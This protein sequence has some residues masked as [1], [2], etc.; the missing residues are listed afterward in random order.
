MIN[1]V[2]IYNMTHGCRDCCDI[3]EKNGEGYAKFPD[4]IY[5]HV[6]MYKNE[7]EVLDSV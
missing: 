3:L 1:N 5:M 6:P 7:H 4:G 2:D